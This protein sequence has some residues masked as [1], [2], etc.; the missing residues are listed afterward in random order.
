MSRKSLLPALLALALLVPASAA[1][2]AGPSFVTGPQSG[3]PLQIA[4]SHVANHLGS[5]GL[6]ADDVADRE[7]RDHYESSNSGMTHIY[8]RQIH[9]GIEV[10]NGDLAVHVAND[11]SIIALHNDFVPNIAGHSLSIGPSLT[12]ESA[13]S[14]AA[15]YLGVALGTQPR[16]LEAPQGNNLSTI[17]GDAGISR[18]PIPARLVWL[19]FQ[20]DVKLVWNLVI[21]RVDAEQWL[22]VRVDAATGDVIDSND[23]IAHGSVP[24]D[25]YRVYPFPA[26][27]PDFSAH[28]KAVAPA[29]PIASPFGWHDTDG[30]DDHD[31]LDTRGNN[32]DANTDYDDNPGTDGDRP[33]GGVA[34]PLDFDFVH[35]TASDPRN[36]FEAAVVNLFYWNNIMHDWTYHYGFNEASGNFQVN[37]YGNGGA[38]NDAVRAEA[39][40]GDDIGNTNNATFG[41]PPDGF[42]PRMRMFR[43]TAPAS[44]RIDTPAGIAGN[45]TAGTADF[46]AD[47]ANTE[48]A[49]TLE[50]AN[51]GD[52]EGGAGTVNDGCQAITP[53][54]LVDGIALI[55][56]GA[57]E[58]G[59]KVLNAENAGY[60]GAIVVNNDGD[61]TLNMAPGVNG[62]SVTI[63][64]LFIGQSDGDAIKANLPTPGV[65]GALVG[66]NPDNDR[67]SDFDNGVIAHE[68]GHGISNRLTGGPSTTG[69]L[70]TTFQGNLTSEQAGEGWSD[71]WALMFATGP[72]NTPEEPRGIGTY[73][74]FEGPGG[75]GIRNFPYSTDLGVNPQTYS[76]VATTN[77]PHG[78][79]EVFM[80]AM[81]EMYWELVQR[82]GMDTDLYNGTGGNNRTIQLVIDGMKLQPCQPTQVEARDAILLADQNL[83]AGANQCAIWRAFAKRGLGVNADGGD[84]IRGDETEDFTIPNGCSADIFSN[85]FES[86]DTTAWD[87]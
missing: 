7:L 66:S 79:G 29:D 20:G 87:N 27:S 68:Y 70:P 58:F 17:L 16:A 10:W 64:S 84:Y 81:W 46:G 71:F 19:P 3:E 26:E 34:G 4:E 51:D 75:L 54:G 1:L 45:Y 61:G 44:L 50:Y 77:A 69:C 74:T 38:G 36:S 40:N 32:V 53:T 39:L 48:E 15:D 24:A 60:I 63:P 30:D 21:D 80:L 86:G 83:Y 6:T 85:G 9:Q 28:V 62:G 8:W 33:S 78:I 41:T 59:L 52:D 18:A 35:D 12:A 42:E 67:D 11:G 25:E 57:C 55:D 72:G 65:T 82:Y 37:N 13:L 23:W 22:N 49:G 5:L 43:W 47:L 14:A 2:A 56:R 31:F 73:L 76:V